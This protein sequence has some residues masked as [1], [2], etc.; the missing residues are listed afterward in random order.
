MIR[1][2]G[3]RAIALPLLRSLRAE[4]FAGAVVGRHARACNLADDRGRV[5]ALALPALGN[6]PFSIVIGGQAGCF[7]ELKDGQR[8]YADAEH[9]VV[10][11]WHIP[12]ANARAWDSTLP[13]GPPV[14]LGSR[15]AA[16]VQPYA[17][18]PEQAGDT[19][20][21]AAM[22][23]LQ[24]RGAQ[25]LHTAL[26]QGHN[27]ADAARQLAGLGHGLT[28]A[29]DDYLLGVMAALWLLDEREEVLIIARSASPHTTFLSRAFLSAAAR[30]QFAEPWHD[31]AGALAR[32][33]ADE[34]ATAVQ[35]IAAIGA[36]S[37][38]D[39]L[40]GFAATLL[41]CQCPCS[42]AWR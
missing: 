27:L 19:P 8:A 35:R 22:A 31:L 29:G 37:G 16:I 41:D 7:A 26:E 40:A 21:A 28:P 15:S 34:C 4:P 42:T 14:R 3:A 1:S 30:G 17:L 20:A 38:R 32:D 18:W 25:A 11:G 24:A 36:S 39:A 10:G 5:I 33:R 23:R 9:I 13:T 12:L 2:P 6:G